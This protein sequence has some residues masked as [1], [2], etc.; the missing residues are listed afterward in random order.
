MATSNVIF[1]PN[2]PVKN[3][4]NYT[5]TTTKRTPGGELGQDEFLKILAV[6]MAN[7]DPLEPVSDTDFIA[8]MAQFTALE[9]MSALNQTFASTQAYSMVGKDVAAIMNINGVN[10]TIYGKVSGVVK[11][12]GKDYL[13]VGDFLVSPSAVQAVYNDTAMDGLITQAASLVGKTVTAEVPAPTENDPSK[14]DKVTGTVSSV[15]VKNGAL[16]AK[17]EDKEVPVTYIT[18]IS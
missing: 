7:Q 12:D 11:K 13:Q 14:T 1:N 6:Q 5:S 18:Q 9:Q 3:A 17:I 15:L 4:T 2:A 10:Q 16:Y 8:Q